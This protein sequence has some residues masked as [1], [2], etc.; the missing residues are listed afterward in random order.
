MHMMDWNKYRK[1]VGAGVNTLS[2]LSPETVKGYGVR[3]L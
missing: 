2:K 1:Q 3:P